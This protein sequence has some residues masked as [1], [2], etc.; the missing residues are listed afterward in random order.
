MSGNINILVLNADFQPINMTTFRKGYKLLYNK[1][2]EVVVA[3]SENPVM[4]YMTSVARPK[5]I[6][7]LK[8][9][10]LPYRKINLNKQNVY[11][12]DGFRC[13]YCNANDNLT[14]DHVLP[15]SRGGKNTWENLVTCCSKCNTKKDNKTPSEAN[16][17]MNSKPYAPTFI[18]LIS[19]SKDEIFSGTFDS[20]IN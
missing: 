5:V 17:K 15:K 20:I 10:Y 19:L 13:V 11:K 16:M 1:K 6:R 2:A 18:K 7:L 8:Y 3:D 9:I 4:L 14:I 12:R